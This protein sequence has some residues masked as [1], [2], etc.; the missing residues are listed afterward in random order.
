M[1]KQLKDVAEYLYTVLTEP[2]VAALR[3]PLLVF[4][5]KQDQMQAK[6]AGLIRTQLEREM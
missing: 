1:Q 3:P 2:T 6:G 5:N 4:C